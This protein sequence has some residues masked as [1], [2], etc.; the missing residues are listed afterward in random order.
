[1]SFIIIELQHSREDA[2]NEIVILLYKIIAD[3][4]DFI[5]LIFE[6]SE[7]HHCAPLLITVC[8]V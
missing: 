7:R 6:V 4:L 5:V 8:H 1:M 3:G 2:K